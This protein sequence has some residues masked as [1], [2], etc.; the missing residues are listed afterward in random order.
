MNTKTVSQ[1]DAAGYFVGATIADESPLEPGVWLIP[2]GA[3]DQEPPA[4]INPGKRYRPDNGRW[5]EDDCNNVELPASLTSNSIE[6]MARAHLTGINQAAARELDAL[7]ASY[8]AGE[9]SS[10]PQQTS[11]ANAILAAPG[12][13][14]ATVAPL[15]YTIA[16][17]R[18]IPVVELANRVLAKVQQFAIVSGQIIGKRQALEDAVAEVDL[19]AADA[20]A[21]LE[22]IAW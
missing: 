18:N 1:L 17:A 13:D 10:W 22:A 12:S 7:T 11:E 2:G 9:V 3:I 16:T 4:A 6:D 15:L 8:P 14:A 5:V 20:I 21:Q 19:Q